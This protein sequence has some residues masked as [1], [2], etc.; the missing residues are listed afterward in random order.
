MGESLKIIK[1]EGDYFLDGFS[2][3]EKL[4]TKNEVSNAIETGGS[5]FIEKSKDL[6]KKGQLH[7]SD[8]LTTKVGRGNKLLWSEKALCKLKEIFLI[9]EELEREF[10]AHY[11][12]L[13]ESIG[14][15]PLAREI[16]SRH[17]I[18][19]PNNLKKDTAVKSFLTASWG[20]FAKKD[21]AELLLIMPYMR[22]IRKE[23]EEKTF[24]S[25]K[26]RAHVKY[27]NMIL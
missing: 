18:D 9:S 3:L 10:C 2:S 26:I 4:F 20:N 6:Q 8:F 15:L 11:F 17:N 23:I 22:A 25:C 5:T 19:N 12:F 7:K 21:K 24:T 1:K 16:A 14:E 27:E 13:T